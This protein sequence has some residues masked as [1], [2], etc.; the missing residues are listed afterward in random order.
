MAVLWGH[1]SSRINATCTLHLTA[2]T[3]D[4]TAVE[5]RHFLR[6]DP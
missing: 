4:S 2:D 3:L 1:Q 6:G 5:R